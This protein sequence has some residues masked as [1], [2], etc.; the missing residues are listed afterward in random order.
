MHPETTQ[1]VTKLQESFVEMKSSV[2]QLVAK[3]AAEIK[4]TGARSAELA[5]EIAEAT[6]KMGETAVQVAEAKALADA[7]Q[8]RID[9][10]EVA[11][12]SRG[13]PFSAGEAEDSPV[14]RLLKSPELAEFRKSKSANRTDPIS[15]G[16]LWVTKAGE[17]TTGAA[18]QLISPIRLPMVAPPQRS[19]RMRDIIPS[20]PAASGAV[21]YIVETGFMK[22]G[23][24]LAVTSATRSSSTATV[25]ATAPHGVPIGAMR[26]VRISG[27]NQADY[28]GDHF[29]L[30]T[31][32]STFT[33]PIDSGATTPATGTI[34]YQ[35]MQ[36]H[37]GATAQ[38]E[39]DAK[40]QAQLV[41]TRMTAN[42]GTVAHYLA[43]TRQVVN[44]D[45]ML[46]SY[47][48]NRLL[49]GLA[50]KEDQD[51]LYGSGVAPNIQGILNAD[52]IQSVLWS[53][54]AT[55][56]SKIDALRKAL[57]R[58]ADAEYEGTAMVVNTWDWQD[59]ELTKDGQ[60]AYVMGPSIVIEGAG[61]RLFRVPVVVTN[62]I[63]QGTALVGAFQQATAIWD[64]EDAT[65][66]ISDSHDDWFIKNQ[67]AI[68][69]EER[70]AQTTFR[71]E[72]FVELTFDSQP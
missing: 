44:D 14:A 15:V 60:K 7:Q 62:A 27:A 20:A 50:Y 43:V 61:G 65:I 12:K 63:A 5:N 16:R 28:N 41:L 25:T 24:T 53:T 19:L 37:G 13:A 57:T 23:A 30:F 26:R 52:G 67:L 69:A 46:Q 42:A 29:A 68:L 55:G 8:K 39:G 35:L 6:R 2:D 54:L 34:L 11:L 72:A 10:L 1:D 21:D 49:Y 40:A 45:A 51:L 3:Q 17:L 70:L 31:G 38:T 56:D 18:T 48:E 22:V 4:Q 47:V 9:E 36:T 59:V 64:V 33:F 71:P 66:R 32:A 58:V